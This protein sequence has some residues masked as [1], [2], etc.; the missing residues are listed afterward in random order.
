[1]I[2]DV[3]EEAVRTLDQDFIVD[4]ATR[5]IPGH[6][7]IFDA[8]IRKMR[9]A[10][11]FVADLTLV[12]R[13]SGAKDMPNPNGLSE[14]GYALAV[15]G[16]LKIIPVMNTSCGR[17]DSLP[18]DL[19]HWSVR[20]QYHVEPHVDGEKR[21]QEGK[22]LTAMLRQEITLVWKKAL[23]GGLTD[24]ELRIVELFV[25]QSERGRPGTPQ[26]TGEQLQRVLNL[27]A[28]AVRRTID[29][30]AGEQLIKRLAV[31][32]PTGGSIAPTRQ[33]FLDFDA[34]FM[35]WDPAQDA[36]TIAEE[37]VANPHPEPH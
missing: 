31:R 15:M 4:E 32:G 2:R 23:S 25:R 11:L 30:L 9:T 36:R 8:I 5:E 18:F 13:Y 17:P 28:T 16:D 1:L 29:K 35:E 10:A 3:L 33:L 27:D 12:G 19:R 34:F 20:V 21:K 37:L 26:L 6:A 7:P 22:R 24:Q 14:Y